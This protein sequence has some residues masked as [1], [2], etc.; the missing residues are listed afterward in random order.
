MKKTI[1]GFIIVLFAFAIGCK[2]PN[3]EKYQITPIE[4]E[5]YIE[6][7]STES[8]KQQKKHLK[9]VVEYGAMFSEN[10]SLYDK[11][12]AYVYDEKGNL[13]SEMLEDSVGNKI[14][15]FHYSYDEDGNLIRKNE[16]IDDILLTYTVYEYD[17]D[18]QLIRL[19]N[20]GKDS[21]DNLTEKE[22]IV[23]TYNSDGKIISEKQSSSFGNGEITYEYDNYGKLIRKEN[24]WNGDAI[25]VKYKYDTRDRLIKVYSD[26]GAVEEYYYSGGYDYPEKKIVSVPTVVSTYYYTYDSEG[27]TIEVI[28]DT[29]ADTNSSSMK[30][31]YEY[32]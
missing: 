15:S 30:I 25:N 2:E 8:G 6:E 4:T 21:F 17:H 28:I 29:I 26:N 22:V 11:I 24:L 16:Y 10:G 7:E 9:K 13:I 32:E 19:T 3:F 5:R 18:G 12:T 23:Y 31:I 14:G 27:N 20:F 1:F